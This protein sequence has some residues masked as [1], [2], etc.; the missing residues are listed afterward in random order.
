MFCA[1]NNV[2]IAP[3][4]P[5]FRKFDDIS[6]EHLYNEITV[7]TGAPSQM[8]RMLLPHMKQRKRGMI[9]FVSSIV[10]VFKSPYFVNYSGTKVRAKAKLNSTIEKSFVSWFLQ[11]YTPSR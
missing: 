9:V 5:T 1:V 10:Q 2:G 3:P 4:H 11:S 8:T 7:N 6:K